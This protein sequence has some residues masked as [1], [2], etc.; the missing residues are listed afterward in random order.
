MFY[1]DIKLF[2]QP[3]SEKYSE[4]IRTK[5]IKSQKE[6]GTLYV[7]QGMPY[8]LKNGKLYNRTTDFPC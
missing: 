4:E 3:V 7:Y 6:L 8:L 1:L 2:T 5:G